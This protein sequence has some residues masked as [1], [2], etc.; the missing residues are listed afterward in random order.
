LRILFREGEEKVTFETHIRIKTGA[1]GG[2]LWT[3]Q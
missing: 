2:L 1:S 3:P